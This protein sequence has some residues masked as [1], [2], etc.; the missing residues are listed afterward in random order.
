MEASRSWRS[1]RT[2]FL[3][4]FGALAILPLVGVAFMIGDRTTTSL[5]AQSLALQREVADG[6]A[7]QLRD[8]LEGRENELVILDRVVGISTAEPQEQRSVLL[9]LLAAQ[10]MYEELA[11]A[12]AEGRERVRVSRG[13]VVLD[14]DLR[15]RGNDMAFIRAAETDQTAFGRVAFDETRRQPTMSIAYPLLDLR[16]GEL[17][18][19]L[20][21]GISFKPVWELLG[22]LDGHVGQT[23]YVVNADGLVVAHRDPPIILR[24]TE[25]ELPDADGRATSIS[26]EE[27]VVAVVEIQ[28]GAEPLFVVAEEPLEAALAVAADASRVAIMITALALIAVAGAVLVIAYRVVRPIEEVAATARR[29]ADGDRSQLLTV[30]GNDEIADLAVAFNQMTLQLD[31]VIQSLERRVAERTQDLED[32]AVGQRELIAELE[33]KNA[34]LVVVKD[35][36]EQMIRSK[37]DFLGAVSHELRTPLTSVVGYASLI[38]DNYDGFD[39]EEQIDMIQRIADQAQDM[40]DIINDLLVVARADGGTLVVDAVAVDLEEAVERVIHS[41]PGVVVDLTNG[42]DM[43]PAFADPGRVRQI[44]RNLVANAVRYGGSSVEIAVSR[45]GDDAIVE[46]RDDGE[47]IPDE[48]WETVFD[49]YRR[50][51]THHHHPAS[52]GLGLSVSRTLAR[53]MGG[54]LTYRYADGLSIF[55]LT[56]PT[57]VA[58]AG[59]TA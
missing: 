10:P 41:M 18:A 53:Q 27:T 20:L 40:A 33:A 56:L 9:D 26:G 51:D 19:V 55:S 42:A 52:V 11:I 36:L 21:A 3:V 58:A 47:G 13:S 44:L 43:T 34:E 54:D 30:R 8:V 31:D 4:V 25:V 16:T 17:D 37:D 22:A 39:P 12:D 1:L 23:V 24:G 35:Q 32:A 29:V 57:C 38:R 6:V 50:A 49:P 5:E 46:V 14:E 15:D 45:S 48:Q 59:R 7:Q 2:R 28:L